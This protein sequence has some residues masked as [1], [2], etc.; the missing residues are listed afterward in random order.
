MDRGKAKNRCDHQ[1]SQ[2]M[3][4]ENDKASQILNTIIQKD[5]QTR[6]READY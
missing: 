4:T 2:W 6:I 3:K 5:L 1:S